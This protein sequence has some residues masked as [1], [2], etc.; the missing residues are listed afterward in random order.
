MDPS[1]FFDHLDGWALLWEGSINV[2]TCYWSGSWSVLSP[3]V[4][5][6]S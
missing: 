4:S 3:L 1:Y 6:V 5:I 2:W